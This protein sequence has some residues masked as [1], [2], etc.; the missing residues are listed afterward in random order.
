MAEHD[1]DQTDVSGGSLSKDSVGASKQSSAPQV[2]PS[3]RKPRVD[4]IQ[5]KGKNTFAVPRNVSALYQTAKKPET[6]EDDDEKPKSNDEF[7]K[8]FIKG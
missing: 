1:A 3:T 7:R 5:L 8:M 6:E 4:T 2:P